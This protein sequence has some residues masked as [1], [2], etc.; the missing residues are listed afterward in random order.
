MAEIPTSAE[1]LAIAAAAWGYAETEQ[2][3]GWQLRAA[4][5]F[6][7]R[8]NSAWPLGPI[9]RP[10]PD[11]VEAVRAWY[12]ARGLPARVQAVAGSE[13]DL[14][15]AGLG[16]RVL[17]GAALRQTARI[18]DVLDILLNVAPTGVKESFSDA[19]T[20]EWLSLYRS[21]D[22]PPAAR[23]VLGSGETVQYATLYDSGTGAPVAIG[24]VALAAAPRGGVPAR[25]AALAAIETAPAARRRGLAKLVI[26]MLLEWAA[27][28]GATHS[29]LEVS[30]DNVPAVKLYESIGFTTHHAYHCRVVG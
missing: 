29:L 1:L 10:L 30:P 24:R 25:W 14:D 3:D 18:D 13:L 12:A 5:G 28:Q 11:A 7:R 15:L 6:T 19:P 17:D 4:D 2:V 20:D 8:A 9:A 22:L 23:H 21:G 27:E 16:H 26:D